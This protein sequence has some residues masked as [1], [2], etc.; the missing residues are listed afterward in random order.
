[1]FER[2]AQCPDDRLY[3]L[4]CPYTHDLQEVITLRVH[5]CR[6]AMTVLGAKGW[7]VYSPIVH[8]HEQSL[9]PGNTL[10]YDYYVKHGLRMLPRMDALIILQLPGWDRS[11]GVERELNAEPSFDRVFIDFPS[12]TTRY[13]LVKDRP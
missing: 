7:L 9:L 10:G 4:A 5:Q 8:W 2:I 13:D 1:M 11:A 3:Y 12:G 6:K